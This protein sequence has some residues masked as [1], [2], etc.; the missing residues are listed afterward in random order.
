M[1]KI[2]SIALI[3]VASLAA[4]GGTYWYFE[5]RET[6]VMVQEVQQETLVQQPITETTKPQKPEN[7]IEPAP[8]VALASPVQEA[9]A[10]PPKPIIEEKPVIEEPKP[11]AQVLPPP[12][13]TLITSP[14]FARRAQS[15][16]AVPIPF[17]PT[18]VESPAAE[19][20][21]SQVLPTPTLEQEPIVEVAEVADVPMEVPTEAPAEAE[22]MIL[23]PK[24]PASPIIPTSRTEFDP[25]PLTWTVGASV[26]FMDFQW[27][28]PERGFDV[29][30][31]V[32]KN[33]EGM[34][35]FGGMAEY[36]K[37]DG[38]Q[39]ISVMATGTWTINKEEALS[40][41]LSISL[42][43]SFFLG[44]N[45]GWGMRAKLNAGI[46]YAITR[47]FRFFY[48][49]GLEMLW[50]ITDSDLRFAL[51]PM[52]VGFSYSF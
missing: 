46:S 44:A 41:P 51:E 18:F 23:T 2:W 6:P 8:P 43:P 10:Q 17:A 37:V 4:V 9:P 5:I 3:V 26:S 29:Q 13:S 11:V 36:A 7:T 52:R 16:P 31:E 20:E 45:N 12:V 14:L 25:T 50:N 34:F 22:K 27:P 32:L 21:E 47:Q 1:N 24:A 35:S 30:L 19:P 33:G 28:G 48:Q 15:A 39:Q 40:F 38:D 42:G 49:A